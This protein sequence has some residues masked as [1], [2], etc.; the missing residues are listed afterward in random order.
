M[1]DTPS[2]RKVTSSTFIET[3]FNGTTASTTKASFGGMETSITFVG[4]TSGYLP[5]PPNDDGVWAVDNVTSSSIR[6][7]TIGGTTW[8]PT[9]T[10]DGAIRGATTGWAS[11]PDP[12]EVPS[13]ALHDLSDSSCLKENGRRNY[14]K[15]VSE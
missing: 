1:P 6:S 2:R 11:W 3:L 4:T 5:S 13:L 8:G 15:G 14:T 12:F 10:E 7:S 9:E